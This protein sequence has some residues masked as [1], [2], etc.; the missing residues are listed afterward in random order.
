MPKLPQIK[1]VRLVKALKKEGWY[2]DR[3]HGSHIIM[4]NESKPD[5][6]IIVPIHGKSLKPGTLSNIVKKA[7]LPIEKLKELL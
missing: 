5:N 6:K 1:G 2:I 7:E 3:T 4:R